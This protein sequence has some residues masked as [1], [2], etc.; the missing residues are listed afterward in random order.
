MM[1][2]TIFQVGGMA[3]GVGQALNLVFPGPSKWLAESLSS[4]LPSVAAA[5]AK[6][7]EHPWA[8]LTALA[9]VALLASGG[10]KRIERITT[11]LVAA[12]TLITVI[13]V[14]MLPWTDYPVRWVDLQDG[15]STK[16]LKV[17]Q[18]NKLAV[19]AAFGAFGI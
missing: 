18:D 11:V 3:G 15:F 16:V 13:C 9:G 4:S 1:S 7:P 2:A 17:L 5:I 8:V 6:R 12:V 14:C 10:Y 19:A